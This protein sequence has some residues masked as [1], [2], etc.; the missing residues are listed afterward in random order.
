MNMAVYEYIA[1]SYGT[2]ISQW[3]QYHNDN[4]LEV[5]PRT[6]NTVYVGNNVTWKIWQ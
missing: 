1:R 5:W 6:L 3:K 4:D 2:A